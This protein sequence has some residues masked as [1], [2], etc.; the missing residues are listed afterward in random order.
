MA[1]EFDI[2]RRNF[3][4]KISD[5]EVLLGIGD[6]AAI[7]RFPPNGN[8]VVATDL[9]VAGRHFPVNTP[10]R[11]IGHRVLAVNLSDMAAMSAI[12]RWAVLQLSIPEHDQAW[13]SDFSDGLFSLADRF[14]VTLVGGDTVCGPLTAGITV[15]G[16]TNQPVTRSGARQGDVI[17]VSGTVGDAF[18]GLQVAQDRLPAKAFVRAKDRFLYPEPRIQLGIALATI[19]TA[20]IDTSDG[21]LAD[22]EKLLASSG[23]GA[24]VEINAVPFS[25]EAESALNTGIEKNRLLNSG[26]DYEL[27]FTLHEDNLES[28]FAISSDLGVAIT[29][30][31]K[32]VTGDSLVCTDNGKPWAFESGGFDHFGGTT[33]VSKR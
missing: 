6:D 24:D 17:C 18:L 30:I 10:A 28:V 19:A 26:D 4:R 25:A 14:G 22:L 31:G 16:E 9:L 29:P 13:L 5:S 20:M 32:I 8:L 12:P 11:A 27:C 7:I 33:H 3:E 1:S 2:I 23:V 15:L 21:L